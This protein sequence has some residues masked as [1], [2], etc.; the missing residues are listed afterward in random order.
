MN[1]GSVRDKMG[2]SLNRR[3]GFIFIDFA[4][5][6]AD[7]DTGSVPETVWPLGGLYSFRTAAAVVEVISDS[8]EDDPD[9]GA[10]VPGTGAHSIT[11]EGLDEDWEPIA[12]TI[13][14][15][16]TAA[17][18]GTLE[19]WRINRVYVHSAGTGLVN[20]G[21]ISVR[22]ASAGT[23][24]NYIA[25][26]D[27]LSQVGVFS[28]P[29]DTWAIAESWTATSRDAS[30]ASSADVKFLERHFGTE[31]TLADPGVLHSHMTMYL[32][33]TTNWIGGLPHPIPPKT[34]IELRVVNVGANN[35]VV[36]LHGYGLLIGPNADV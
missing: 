20:A 27:G 25:A 33:N 6:N 4:C 9:K 3:P 28:T 17:V 35:T 5:Y 12:E 23:T 16:G 22:D 24:R 11:V 13:A 32:Q 19:F 10:G 34:D 30:L 18:S 1:G 21:N 36:A 2:F 26:G 7:V 15:N 14:L 8:V 31:H 29:A